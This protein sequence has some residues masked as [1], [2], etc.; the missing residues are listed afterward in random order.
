MTMCFWPMHSSSM[1]FVKIKNKNSIAWMLKISFYIR[2]HG[3]IE[4]KQL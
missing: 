1:N 3:K 2:V 4:G